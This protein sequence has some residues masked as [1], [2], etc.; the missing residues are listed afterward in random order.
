[1]TE[2]LRSFK[3]VILA[4][5]TL[6]CIG[7]EKGENILGGYF[8]S[9]VYVHNG[10]ELVDAQDYEIKIPSSGGVIDLN[11][12]SYGI[13]QIE[14]NDPEDNIEVKC[15]SAYPPPE[16]E[17][18]DTVGTTGLINRYLQ[19]V[20]I[21]ASKNTGKRHKALFTILVKA[22]LTEIQAADIHVIQK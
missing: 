2:S 13:M 14:D 7:C 11:I 22:E 1:M 10:S 15:L 12:V 20:R 18:Y 3:W 16:D 19:K 8:Y 9:G 5:L 4:V 21:S 6:T 17:I